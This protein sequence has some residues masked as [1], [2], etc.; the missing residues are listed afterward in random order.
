MLIPQHHGHYY[1]PQHRG[2][3]WAGY[4]PRGP[5]PSPTYPATPAPTSSHR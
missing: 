1:A 3:G 4:R 2:R 5:V